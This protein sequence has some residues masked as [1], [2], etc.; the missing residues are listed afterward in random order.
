MEVVVQARSRS[1]PVLL[2]NT[3]V[4]LSLL[5]AVLQAVAL[6]AVWLFVLELRVVL[7]VHCLW[8]LGLH[9]L[10]PVRAV[11]PRSVVVLAAARAATCLLLEAPHQVPPVQEDLSPCAVV[12]ELP[13]EV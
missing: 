7:A 12:V 2:D 1:H 4:G 8:P 10:G 3:A 13:V 6:P 11:A 9:K 5:P